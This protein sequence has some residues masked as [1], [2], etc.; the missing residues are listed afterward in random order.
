MTV[1]I[2]PKTNF[3]AF[4][5]DE[6]YWYLN[7]KEWTKTRENTYIMTMISR[8]PRQIV[9]YAVDTSVNAKAIQEM[10]DSVPSAERYYSDGCL[11]YLDVVF[12]GRYIRNEH[13][14]NDTHNVES[15]NSDLRHYI[16]GL[17]RRSK[18]FYRSQETLRAVLGVFID[19]YNKFGEAK[20]KQRKNSN[21]RYYD[22]PFSV[23]DFL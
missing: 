20:E 4:E 22:P 1:W 12:G 16:P 10:A 3:D 17:K 13:N 11:V 2:S 8:K 7:R 18:C 14:K 19:A 6:V 5:L 9:G 23:L 21:Q 15:T